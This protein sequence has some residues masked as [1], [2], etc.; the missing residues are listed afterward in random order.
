MKL[1]KGLFAKIFAFFVVNKIKRSYQK[2]PEIQQKI[3]K[4]LVE[5]S[6]KTAFGIEHNFDEI[7]NHEDFIKKVPVRDYEQIKKYIERIK[8][9][10]QDVLW[11]GK[12]KYLA[13]TSGTTSGIKQIPITNESMPNHILSA[14]NA[15]LFYI[16]ETGKTNFLNGKTIFIQGSPILN[17][18]NGIFEG[19][20]SG[21]VAHHIPKYLRKNNLPT[22][23]TNSI[24]DWELK[25]DQI[26]EETI[27][28]NMTV[29][30]GIPSWVQMYFE[31]ILKKTKK[32][33][34]AELFNEF[35]LYI[36]GGVNFL[37]Y[38]NIFKK[39]IG[40]QIDTIEYYPASEGFFAYQNSQLDK[41]LLLQYNSGIYYEFIK[42]IEFENEYAK[43]YNLSNVK[44]ETNYVL[45]ISNNAGLWAYNTGDTIKF[46]SLH[47]PK[48]LVTGR[49]K[50]FISAFG[51]HVISEEVEKSISELCDRKE[52][53]IRE[54]TV[55]PMINPEKG[56]PHHEWWIE[57]ENENIDI[58]F[59]EK[60]LDKS[61]QQKNIYYKDLVRG[62][63]LKS[64]K[65]IIVKKGG[66]NKH[67][68]SIG[69]LGGQNKVPKLSNN[70][71]FVSGLKSYVI[72]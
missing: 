1:F 61:M 34:L 36:Y 15:L 59:A 21:I 54:F 51:E 41:S 5:N 30:G 23:K 3:L 9:G 56:L 63:V 43:R 2:A 16:Y 40:K 25:V 19:R 14:R 67:M 18:V 52:I 28:E 65:I 70:R 62:G 33:N 27:N 49:Y 55:A 58:G 4:S 22:F 17:S 42:T 68:K 10:E 12:P 24:E 50:H 47:P 8:K 35:N 7:K 53:N 31:N 38:K 60:V 46:T 71:D 66:F 13:K 20:L 64:L 69:K 11:P 37:P 32:K 48:I 57:F 29:I 72:H 39:L 26:C 44:I 45:I 6:K